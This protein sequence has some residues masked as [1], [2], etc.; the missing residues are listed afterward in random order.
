MKQYSS[1]QATTTLNATV[2]GQPWQKSFQLG[3]GVDAVTG[4]LRASAVK[5]FKP[6]PQ[7]QLNPVFVYSLIQSESDLQSVISGSTKASYNL[8][9]VTLS[10]SASFLDSIAVSE[11]AVTVVA[12]V[13]VQES[14]YSK[15]EKYEL[16]VKPDSKF[17]DN[18]GD[19]FI[20]AIALA[21]PYTLSTNVTSRTPKAVR[22]SPPPWPPKCR[23][24]SAPRGAP[25]SRKSRSKTMQASVSVSLRW[26]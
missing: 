2:V 16:A 5:P 12:Q 9:G 23:R 15:A 1:A 22:N 17:R 4:Q 21:H 20:A 8:E 19:Y 13:S 3:L 24:S 25:A 14:E 26:G 7:R 18:Y 10:A 11:L 6:I